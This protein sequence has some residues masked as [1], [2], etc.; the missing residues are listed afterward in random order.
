MSA[1]GVT[2]KQREQKQE[3]QLEGMEMDWLFPPNSGSPAWL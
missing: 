1:I 3:D 2:L